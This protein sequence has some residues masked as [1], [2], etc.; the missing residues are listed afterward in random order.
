M[1]EKIDIETVDEE[2]Y[3]LVNPLKSLTLSQIEIVTTSTSKRKFSYHTM[4]KVRV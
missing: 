4:Y 2:R 1:T 3:M